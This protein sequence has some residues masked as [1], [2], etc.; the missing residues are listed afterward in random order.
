[1]TFR[2]W[3]ERALDFYDGLEVDNSKA[4]WLEHKDVYER[5]V[6]A[7]MDALLA[8]LSP[9]FGE[10]RLFRPYRDTRFSR[11]K[12]PYK[13]AIAARI[14][15]GYVQLSANGLVAGAGMYHLAPDQLARYRAAVDAD[16]PG[17]GLQSIVDTLRDAR[18]EVT[19][20]ETLKSTPRGY[21]KDHPRIDLLRHKGLVAMKAWPVA[22]WLGTAGAKKRIAEVFHS[23]APLLQWL[24]AHVGPAEDAADTGPG[25]AGRTRTRT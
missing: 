21:A 16:G 4:Y 11:D 2:G 5:D 25:R 23:S 24:H 8:E 18:L 6:K 9:Q 14:G 3:P 12:S 10:A 17:R 20:M 13:T 1:M 22:S 19:A 7:P 15:D